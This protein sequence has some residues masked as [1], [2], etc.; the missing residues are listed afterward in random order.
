MFS[1]SEVRVF[2][3][4]DRYAV[5][6]IMVIFFFYVEHGFLDCELEF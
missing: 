2:S 6:W 5:L 3:F 1:L 4:L